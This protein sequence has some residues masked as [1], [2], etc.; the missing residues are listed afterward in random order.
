MAARGRATPRALPAPLRERRA[1]GSTGTP[2][3]AA[4]P[5]LLAPLRLGRQNL[6]QDRQRQR[7][8]Q[9]PTVDW[10]GLAHQ[11]H[12]QLQQQQRHGAVGSNQQGPQHSPRSVSPFLP[13]LVAMQHPS[14][15]SNSRAD[16][17]GLLGELF[18]QHQVRD[19]AVLFELF[20]DLE[21]VPRGVDPGIIDARTTTLTYD[22]TAAASQN[23][24][25]SQCCVCL[26]QFRHGEEL[27][28]LPCMHR[29]HRACIDRWL[30]RSPACP[31]CKYEIS[32]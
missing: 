20:G 27:R 22:G 14:P 17:L 4:G 12:Q 32:H 19:P 9:G 10:R 6:S 16:A 5:P 18:G 11:Q 28:M 1:A 21:A 8:L 30:A 25:Q 3:A 26:E 31:V 13:G 7:A 15:R 23:S 2:D 29:Y 24:P